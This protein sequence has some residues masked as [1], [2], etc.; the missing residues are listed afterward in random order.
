MDTRSVGAVRIL[1]P[2]IDPRDLEAM[3]SR[4]IGDVSDGSVDGADWAGLQL[5]GARIRNSQFSGGTLDNSS[6]TDVTVYGCRFNRVD[7]SGV[8]LTNV[9]LERCEFIG[10]R[11]TGLG[12]GA[13][14]LKDVIFEKCRLD[15]AYFDDVRATGATAWTGC[16]MEEATLARCQLQLA[17]IRSCKLDRLELVDCTLRG[18]DLGGSS[19]EGLRGALNL[20]GARLERG[21]LN[22]LAEALAR[23]LNIELVS[24][25]GLG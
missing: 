12:I 8:K 10:C 13:S 1:L 14:K 17:A 16:T 7:L 18:T 19:L 20:R 23:D 2:H 5:T 3:T 24:P 6:L 4:P 9:T 15:Y 25:T 21:Q 22:E 11:M